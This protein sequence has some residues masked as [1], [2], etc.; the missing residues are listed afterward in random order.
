[1]G[2]EFR[3]TSP[4]LV[5]GLA[6][7]A[8]SLFT[9]CATSKPRSVQLKA[10]PSL[11]PA[12]ASFPTNRSASSVAAEAI[13]PAAPAPKTEWLSLGPWAEAHL[14]GALQPVLGTAQPAF[15]LITPYGRWRF[16]AGSALTRFNDVPYWLGYAPQ[17]A[18]GQLYLH[19]ADAEKNLLALAQS[20]PWVR[21]LQTIVIDPGHGGA[22][23][24]TR[25]LD[26]KMEK[27]YTLEWGLRLASLLEQHGWRVR[28][29][30]TNDCDVGL[31]ERVSIAESVQADL[32]LSLHFNSSLP[33]TDQEGIET[34]CL[35]PAGLPS[36][37][38][39]EYD[40]DMTRELPNNAYDAENLVWAFAVH[41]K[42]VERTGAMDRGVRR[43]RFMGVLQN[44]RRPAVL[45]EAGYLSH[46]EEGAKIAS[47]AYLQK[48]A[49][50]VA[51]A[52][53]EIASPPLAHSEP[54]VS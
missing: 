17:A 19:Q 15:D 36:T 9:G 50:A 47:P 42:L 34:Y 23:P 45:L 35:T 3:L 2:L 11:S 48:L 40:D 27:V 52:L 31:T 32:F 39:R 22:A 33:R 43:A 5:S 41:R 14:E 24:G 10:V 30:R 53:R 44:Q 4:A 49:E 51:D 16:V 6:V 29:T 7:L 25:S 38:T 8:V 21:S 54:P 37:L 13:P 1:M 12:L 46:A 18:N 20:Q 28:L 26:G